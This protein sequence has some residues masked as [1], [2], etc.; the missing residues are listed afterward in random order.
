M[1]MGN[2][3]HLHF[4]SQDVKRWLANPT[5]DLDEL[6]PTN[7]GVLTAKPEGLHLV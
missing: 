6:D 5:F 2:D 7:P 1:T 3:D 4:F